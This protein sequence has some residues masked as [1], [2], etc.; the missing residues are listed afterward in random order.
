MPSTSAVYDRFG[1]GEADGTPELVAVV[2]NEP[3]PVAE[4]SPVEAQRPDHLALGVAP[5]EHRLD[6]A[7][8]GSVAVAGLDCNW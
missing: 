4:R 7:G 8:R 6:L 1:L 2:R 5:T 3:G